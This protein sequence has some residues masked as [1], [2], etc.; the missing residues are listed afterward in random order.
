MTVF[1]GNAKRIDDVDLPRIGER[2]GVGE[3]V[4][5]AF[6]EVEAAGSGFDSQGRVKML[7]EPHIFFRL[8]KGTQRDQAVAEGLAYSKWR[9]GY[10]KDSYPRLERAMEINSSAALKAASWGLG[11]VLG[12]NHHQLGYDSVEDMVA[13]FAEDEENQVE[14][15]VQFTITNHIDD[16][17]KRIQQKID[18]GEKVTAADAIPIVRVYNGPKFAEND[19]H[20]RFVKALY[21]WLRIKNTPYG[22]SSKILKLAEAEEAEYTPAAEEG[23]EEAKQHLVGENGPELLTPQPSGEVGSSAAP[24]KAGQPVPTQAATTGEAI[25]GGHP[26]DQSKQVTTGGFASK[27]WAALGGLSGMGVAAGGFLKGN[28]AIIIV[29]IICVTLIIFVIIFRQIIMDYV[30][31]QLGASPDKYNVK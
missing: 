14:G 20:N 3:D 19:Y 6:L 26:G 2:I 16:D 29:G 15:L 10:P 11:Q 9:R 21:R 7:F 23:S 13:D 5:H 31:M 17:L 22:E 27:V 8:L 4:L 1:K 30:R 24:A 28:T 18:R 12:E 25:V